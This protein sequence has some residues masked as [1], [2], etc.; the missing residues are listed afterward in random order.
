MVGNW[1]LVPQQNVISDVILALPTLLPINFAHAYM[2]LIYN[3]KIL[4]Q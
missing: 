4:T 2:S 3:T 1:Y